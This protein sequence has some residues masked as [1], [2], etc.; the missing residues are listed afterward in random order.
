MAKDLAEMTLTEL[1]KLFPIVHTAH[2]PAWAAWYAEEAAAL[3]AAF[4][5]R[6]RRTSHIGS[7][8]VPGLTAKPTVDILLELAPGL[9]DAEILDRLRPGGWL[10]MGASPE[11][12]WRLDLNKGYTPQGFAERVFHLHLRRPG[13]WDELYFCEYLKRHPEAAAEYAALKLRLGEEFRHHRDHY[14]EA[15]TPFIRE[16]TARARAEFPGKFLPG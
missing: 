2:N 1:W 7:T 13:D 11:P 8:A 16:H 5:A 10:P 14:T 6:R 3:A 15:K 9:T 4:G 12:D